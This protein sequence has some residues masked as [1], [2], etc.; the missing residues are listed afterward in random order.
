MSKTTL[1]YHK[2]HYQGRYDLY[3]ELSLR[4]IPF[5]DSVHGVWTIYGVSPSISHR[6]RPLARSLVPAKLIPEAP[7]RTSNRTTTNYHGGNG[8]RPSNSRDMHNLVYFVVSV[9]I[10]CFN[11]RDVGESR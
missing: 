4:I 11:L 1:D 7:N 6:A 5:R 2:I 3:D 10:G 9:L 8:S